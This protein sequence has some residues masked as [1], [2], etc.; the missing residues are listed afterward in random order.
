MSSKHPS[1]EA[2]LHKPLPVP[3]DRSR[4]YWE[5]AARHQLAIQRCCDCGHFAHPPAVICQACQSA[6]PS[7]RF[8][9]VSG[10]GRIR[11]WTVMRDTFLPG[12]RD[13]VPYVIVVVE[14]DGQPGLTVLAN[15]KDGASAPIRLGDAVEVLF[16]DVADGRALPQ[17][18]L[19]R[20]IK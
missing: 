1:F 8:E 17:F 6:V 4:G 18:R 16:D 19:A 20:S 13:Q 7:F 15:L 10:H 3:D 5:A 2:T 14:L 11:T 9:V 12:F